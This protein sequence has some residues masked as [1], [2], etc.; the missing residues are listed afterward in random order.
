MKRLTNIKIRFIR[1]K[2][3]TKKLKF[4]PIL[5]RCR[6]CKSQKFLYQNTKLGA[7]FCVGFYKKM[8]RENFLLHQV[9]IR[10]NEKAKI[11]HVCLR[12]KVGQSVPTVVSTMYRKECLLNVYQ[13]LLIRSEERRVGKECRYWLWRY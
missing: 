4:R 6:T 9:Y 3:V 7:I 11:Q 1:L 12:V 5:N 13:R 2:F 8:Y 10:S